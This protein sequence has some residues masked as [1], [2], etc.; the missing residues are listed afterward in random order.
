[1]LL[2]IEVVN[3]GNISINLVITHGGGTGSITCVQTMIF[4]TL[5]VIISEYKSLR[6]CTHTQIL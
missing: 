5:V 2:C 6:Y 1:M 4:I 3:L